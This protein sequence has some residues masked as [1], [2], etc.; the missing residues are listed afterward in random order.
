VLAVSSFTKGKMLAT[1]GLSAGKAKI[2]H[3]TLDPAFRTHVA[4][5]AKAGVFRKYKLQGTEKIIF[6]LCRISAKEKEKGYEKVIRSLP[7]L[8]KTHPSIK[9]I[10][11]GKEE[12]AT[13]RK[14]LGNLIHELQLD[15]H[16]IVTG[17]LTDEEVALHY[18]LCD[19]FILPSTKE[20]FGIV[21]LEALAWG[22]PVIAGNAD[23]SREALLNGELGMLVN[24]ADENQ[25][26]AALATVLDG[27]AP[28]NYLNRDY[29]QT[30]VQENFGFEA[31]EERVKEI[32]CA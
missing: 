32:L 24:P 27:K 25:I 23:G 26:Q 18:A 8:L 16:V 31:Y 11:A 20:G 10:I 9:Y 3:N 2:L 5:T 21:F 12:D 19:V 22:K 29:L 13:E 17:Y 4:S 14:R 15:S 30:T 28:E 7:G 1:Q 6:T